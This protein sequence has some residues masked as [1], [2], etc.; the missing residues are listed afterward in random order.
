M[1][2]LDISIMDKSLDCS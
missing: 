1:S 2:G